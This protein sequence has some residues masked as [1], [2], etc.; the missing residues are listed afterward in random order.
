MVSIRA[1][2]TSRSE[3]A[4]PSSLRCPVPFRRSQRFRRRMAI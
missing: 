1:M 4:V 2:V 3:G